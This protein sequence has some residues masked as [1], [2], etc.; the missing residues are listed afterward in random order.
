MF[1]NGV[2]GLANRIVGAEE[3]LKVRIDLNREEIPYRHTGAKQRRANNG[4]A[5]PDG[6][7]SDMPKTRGD[8]RGKIFC[9]LGRKAQLH[10]Q[11]RDKNN[12]QEKSNQNTDRRENAH[13][14]NTAE[15]IHAQGEETQHGCKRSN[16]NRRA[17]FP[18]GLQHNVPHRSSRLGQLIILGHHVE[19][20][21]RTQHQN[22]GRQGNTPQAEAAPGEHHNSQRPD[23]TDNNRQGR[24][25]D[26]PEG[27]KAEEEHNHNSQEG[28]WDEAG[29][30]ALHGVRGIDFEAR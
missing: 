1:V 6:K 13:V 24:Q 20:I 26:T 21:G 8:P 12:R 22:Q 10:E 5:V 30:I 14:S 19:R 25:Q 7:A 9:R 2:G 16:K 23:Q 27:A 3:R 29:Y 28:Q 4:Q 17:G 11:G 15:R 18:E